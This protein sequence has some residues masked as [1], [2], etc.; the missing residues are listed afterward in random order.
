MT[1]QPKLL[2]RVFGPVNI[3]YKSV[4]VI[5]GDVRAYLGYKIIA[6]NPRAIQ[7]SARFGLFKVINAAYIR[8]GTDGEATPK[9]RGDY[10]I[11]QTIFVKIGDNN[12]M[13]K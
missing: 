6:S 7:L 9:W 12:L 1:T 2:P 5:K 13:A 11:I 3:R 8:Q 10:D 4:K